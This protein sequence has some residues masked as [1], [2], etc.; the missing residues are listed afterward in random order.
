M[1]DSDLSSLFSS[2]ESEEKRPARRLN[3]R[4][5]THTPRKKAALY[6]SLHQSFQAASQTRNAPDEIPEKQSTPS[7][8]PHIQVRR[9]VCLIMTV[10]IVAILLALGGTGV[11]YFRDKLFS[12]DT[13]DAT[14]SS[15]PPASVSAVS[16]KAA[17]SAANASLTALSTSTGPIGQSNSTATASA[18]A[19]SSTTTTLT[20]SASQ[21]Y[22]LSQGCYGP[23]FFDCFSF[24]S[25]KGVSKSTATSSGLASVTNS[26][27]FLR[28]NSWTDL[29]EEQ[30]R[31]HIFMEMATTYRY[32]LLIVDVPKIPWECGA[33]SSI[34]SDTLDGIS[35]MT[36]STPTVVASDDGCKIDPLSSMTGTPLDGQ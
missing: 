16:A 22:D 5:S 34:F 15:T 18:S 27:A 31:P 33:W 25:D 36:Q 23:G 14:P 4:S 29:T 28:L 20:I 3:A 17:T 12:S 32:G 11:W 9:K 19:S 8:V 30:T 10:V 6:R 13:A 35:L 2:S 7:T 24:K 1:S 26:S 21:F